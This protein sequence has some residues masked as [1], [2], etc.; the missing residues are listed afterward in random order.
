M[1]KRKECR[2]SQGKGGEISQGL[3]YSLNT[4]KSPAV[5]RDALGVGCRAKNM[6]IPCWI[7]TPP[8]ATQKEG[9]W[10]AGCQ[11]LC[12]SVESELDNIFPQLF[13]SQSYMQ[14]IKLTPQTRSPEASLNLCLLCQFTEISSAPLLFPSLQI[15]H[16]GYFK[17]PALDN[18]LTE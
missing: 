14:G 6:P 5:V 17:L 1:G 11:L 7:K 15:H 13:P 4:C 16:C 8:T 3:T 2:G 18:L 9:H 12:L 10:F